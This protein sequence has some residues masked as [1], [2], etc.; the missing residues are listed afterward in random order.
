MGVINDY[1]QRHDGK[2]RV[3]CGIQDDS[4]K[5]KDG[6]DSMSLRNFISYYAEDLGDYYGEDF[7]QDG[8]L[9]ETEFGDTMIFCMV[10]NGEDHLPEDIKK[11]IRKAGKWRRDKLK[12]QWSYINPLNRIHGYII[13]NDVTNENTPGKTLSISTVCATYFTHKR[14]IGSRLMNLAKEYAEKL[15]YDNIVL[16]VA[17]EYSGRGIEDDSDSDEES[18]EEED[19]EEASEESEDEGDE[20]YWSPDENALDILGEEFWKKCMRKD[21]R[22]IPYFNL[23]KEYIEELI[24]SYLNLEDNSV[25]ELWSGTTKIN[26]SEKDDP[27]DYEYDG[28]WYR[29]GKKSQESLMKF[30]E[31]HG[32]KEDPDVHFNW[33]CFSEIPYPTMR[34]ELK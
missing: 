24:S 8:V 13:L 27:E 31:K 4:R 5:T 10:D 26:V 34:L 23:E 14:G 25:E 32:Y 12:H 2:N 6:F 19:S 9:D 20:D 21:R 17:N 7:C 30:Y 15:G 16:E 33:C 29:R 1:T 22:E 3:L 11:K 28:F 18:S